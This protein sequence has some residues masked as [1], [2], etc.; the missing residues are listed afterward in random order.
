MGW[1]NAYERSNLLKRVG[2][3]CL[4]ERA[5]DQLMWVNYAKNHTGFVIGLDAQAPFFNEDGRLL[6][7]VQYQGSPRVFPVPNICG[8]FYKASL[9]KHEREW[10]CVRDFEESEAR[11]VPI[12]PSLITEIVIGH[13]METWN[14]AQLALRVAGQEISHVRFFLSSP[15]N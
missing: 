6:R 14:V 5:D 15:S 13:K 7:K 8:C 11:L 4:T 1:S 12:D 10:R 2:V 9:W 3:L